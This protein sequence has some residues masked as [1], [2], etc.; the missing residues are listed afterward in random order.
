MTEPNHVQS[1]W[2]AE[3]DQKVHFKYTCWTIWGWQA[4]NL[5]KEM[6]THSSI[7]AWRI[8]GT[9]EP[10]GLPSTGSHRVRPDWCDLAVA[11]AGR[12]L[13]S[14]KIAGKKYFPSIQSLWIGKEKI[15]FSDKNVIYILIRPHLKRNRNKLCF[16]WVWNSN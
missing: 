13:Y 9:E 5:E 4:I 1:P 7:L 16:L 15:M 8:P 3:N 10:G 12:K 14:R 2:K 11:A 6:A